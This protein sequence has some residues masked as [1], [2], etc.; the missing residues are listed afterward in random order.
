MNKGLIS[1]GSKEATEAASEILKLGGNAFDAAICAVMTSMTSEVNLTSMAGGGAMLAY[2]KGEKPLLFDFFVNAPSLK[3]NRSFEFYKTDINFGDTTQ[4]FHIGKGSI[5]VPGNVKGL[6]HTHKR[7][8]KLP[9]RIVC[10]PAIE[11]ARNGTKLS[12]SQS[13]ITSLLQKILQTSEASKKL[14]FQDD[15]LISEGDVFKNEDLAEFIEWI[16][17]DG[18]RPFYEG[19]LGRK[20][21]DYLGDDGLISQKDLLDYQV[22]EREPL[23]QVINSKLLYANPS[24]SVGGTLIVFLLRMLHRINE[25][26]SFSHNL[27]VYLMAATTKARFEY[28]KSPDDEYQLNRILNEDVVNRYYQIANKNILNFTDSFKDNKFGST[29]HV[30]VLDKDGNAASVTTTNGESC[31]HVL[32]GTGV[33]LNNMLGEEDLNPLGFH[34]WSDSKR[35]PTLICPSLLLTKEGAV[36][37]VLGSAGSNRIRSAIVQVILNYLV[38]G[39]SLEESICFPRIHLEGHD[40]HFEPGINFNQ[41]ILN[42]KHISFNAFSDKNLFFGGV[43]SVSQFEAVADPR[44]GGYGLIC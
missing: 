20:M 34:N 16:S 15:K 9:F 40:L 22:V 19:E 28:F 36:D 6:L 26:Y 42:S 31:G 14:F 23:K 5:A 10:E 4:I 21:I 2:K 18:D 29:T 3:D 27:L 13:Y 32:P 41:D 35:L 1:T 43:N 44:R 25:T 30:S 7:L 39:M 33:I 24:P 17:E 37:L 38:K 11:I 8:G 12:K